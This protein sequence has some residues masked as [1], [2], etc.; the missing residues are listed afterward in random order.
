MSGAEG[1]W[2]GCGRGQTGEGLDARSRLL[3]L[4]ASRF[5]EGIASGGD[6]WRM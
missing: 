5:Q 3:S 4:I 1:R 2:L 6:G